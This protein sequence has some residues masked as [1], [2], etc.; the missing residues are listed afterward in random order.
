[1][2]SQHADIAAAFL[3]LTEQRRAVVDFTVP[4]LVVHVTLLYKKSSS[5]DISTVEE[6]VGTPGKKISAI[7]HGS[8]EKFFKASRLPMPQKINKLMLVC[9]TVNGS[10]SWFTSDRAMYLDGALTRMEAICS[11][12]RNRKTN[13]QPRNTVANKISYDH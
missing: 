10:Y 11:L 13:I 2:P 6:L 8:T 7:Q 4:L 9:N 3:S 12:L 1:M 5:R